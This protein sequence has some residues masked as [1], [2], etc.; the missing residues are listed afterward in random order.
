M[1]QK[2]EERRGIDRCCGSSRD[3]YRESFSLGPVWGFHRFV[4]VHLGHFDSGKEDLMTVWKPDVVPV[5]YCD[6]QMNPN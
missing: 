5:F 6:N 2:S 3:S 4:A 1:P